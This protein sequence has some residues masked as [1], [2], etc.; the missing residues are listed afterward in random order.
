[1]LFTELALVITF[2]AI[3]GIAMTWLKQP[4]LLGYLVAGFFLALLGH[5]NDSSMTLIDSLASMGVALLLFL[6][7][8]EMNFEKI[9]HLSS[10][11]VIIGLVQA[12]V[13]IGL[14]FGMLKLLGMGSVPAIYL[15]LAFSFSSTIVV[16][17]LLSEKKDLN[18]LYGRLVVGM[19]LLE[20]F[21]AIL[22]IV[23]LQGFAL[24]TGRNIW[25]NF[26]LTLIK[27]S[28]AFLI[29]ILISKVMPKVLKFIGTRGEE[30]FLFSIAWGVG[31]AALMATDK[32]GLGIEAGGFLAGLAFAKSAEHFEV[33]NKIKWLRDFFI[34]LFFVLLGAR[35]AI[36][37]VN[38]LSVLWISIISSLF[39]LIIN[40]LI[41]MVTMGFL[42][43]QGRTA[44]LAG[45]M[46]AQISEFSLVIA[47]RGGTLGYLTR[48]Q[49]NIVT[50]VGI[51][52]IVVSSYLIMDSER[53]YKI[54][55]RYIKLLEFGKT[56]RIDEAKE[57]VM[58][59]HIVLIGAHRMGQGIIKALI[60][61]SKD[62]SVIDFD[63]Q[64]VEI[65]KNKG[66]KVF[67]GDGVDPE[68]QDLSGFS[69]AKLIIST[70]PS[71][72]DNAVIL[73]EARRVNKKAK[74]ILTAD[75]EWEGR[76]LY[77][78]GADYVIMPHFLEGGH[79][80]E[81]LSDNLWSK[82]ILAMRVRDLQVIRGMGVK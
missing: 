8:L 18:S 3:L 75:S 63:P 49:V 27:G 72:E 34:L 52:T 11:I 73:K 37:S 76:E 4:S 74:I 50:L 58:K 59:N 19:M 80:G 13:P 12:I 14:A 47:S 77:D 26:G 56:K 40:P 62:F 23:F 78:A 28:I 44:F 15:A 5:L 41:T 69:K 22:M 2:A 48:E 39:I 17:K 31:I 46:T 65:L 10:H 36:Q 61:S 30:I 51:I 70:I 67:Y 57:A 55:Y 71:V 68:A 53:I 20:D 25:M 9:K 66:I 16:V 6:V 64:M 82:K 1:M 42:G 32:I 81:I 35:M 7:G 38:I 24:E 21:L 33:A 43:Y 60:D 54:F 29:T 45:I 79:L